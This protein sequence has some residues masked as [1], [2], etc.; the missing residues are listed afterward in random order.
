MTM[1]NKL[2]NGWE[3]PIHTALTN[4]I[5]SGQVCNRFKAM[6]SLME[7]GSM[8]GGGQLN[9][10]VHTRTHARTHVRVCACIY[11]HTYTYMYVHT[12]IHTQSKVLMSS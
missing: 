4:P 10:W 5:L 8:D 9:V 11:I 6:F 2:D 7:E 12:Y 3:P 1:R